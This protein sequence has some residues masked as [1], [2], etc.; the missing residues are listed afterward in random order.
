MDDDL[1]KVSSSL[2]LIMASS[3]KQFQNNIVPDTL[4]AEILPHKTFREFLHITN[5]NVRE[6]AMLK[7]FASINVRESPKVMWMIE[8]EMLLISI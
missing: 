5:I 6:W 1:T 7:D 4:S 2:F 8:P 3:V